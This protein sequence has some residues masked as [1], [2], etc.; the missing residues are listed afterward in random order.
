MWSFDTLGGAGLIFFER[1]STIDIL[2]KR[3]VNFEYPNIGFYYVINKKPI[4]YECWYCNIASMGYVNFQSERLRNI[5]EDN[6]LVKAAA[7]PLRTIRNKL[8]EPKFRM[9]LAKGIIG[10]EVDI[11]ETIKEI[12][13]ESQGQIKTPSRMLI[14]ILEYLDQDNPEPAFQTQK[15]MEEYDIEKKES[16]FQVL[17]LLGKPFAENIKNNSIIYN[18]RKVYSDSIFFGKIT[19]LFI[20]NYIPQMPNSTVLDGGE[21]QLLGEFYSK[22]EELIYSKYK[23]RNRIL[24]C[25]G[26]KHEKDVSMGIR[27][28]AQVKEIIYFFQTMS[29]LIKTAININIFDIEQFNSI[30]SDKKYH[31]EYRKSPILFNQ[32]S[33]KSFEKKFEIPLYSSALNDE[34]Y[35]IILS[36]G[37][38]LQDFMCQI[39]YRA[40]ASPDKELDMNHVEYL[41]AQANSWTGIFSKTVKMPDF[42]QNS[43]SVK[44]GVDNPK[45]NNKNSKSGVLI[46]RYIHVFETIWSLWNML[47]MQFQ[48]IYPRTPVICPRTNHFLREIYNLLEFPENN[49]VFL[50]RG[51]LVLNTGTAVSSID[52][53][54]PPLEI[55]RGRI[56]STQIIPCLHYIGEKIASLI[57]SINHFLEN[58]NSWNY[59]LF[60]I[61]V[62]G[63]ESPLKK[64]LETMRFRKVE[65]RTILPDTIEEDWKIDIFGVE[66]FNFSESDYYEIHKELVHV[67]DLDNV[68]YMN[69][70]KI[71]DS[72]N[73]LVKCNHVPLPPINYSTDSPCRSSIIC[74]RDIATEEILETTLKSGNKV[75]I[76]TIQ[77]E[78][79]H[80]DKHLMEE[81]LEYLDGIEDAQNRFDHLKNEITKQ[82]VDR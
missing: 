29:T 24:E 61:K 49:Q 77:P 42:P 66:D 54:C 63:V 25:L 12:F 6:L 47:K 67:N 69:Y 30:C 53:D 33:E 35:E 64:Y 17:Q 57:T 14:R 38:E 71:V 68:C 62:E 46:S 44:W 81:L 34:D 82:L 31:L 52:E 55:S 28:N 21:R 10:H 45:L 13:G 73:N 22:L 1:D 20:D 16:N 27:E 74:F 58:K 59:T 78:F 75:H 23:N 3:L 50:K 79:K 18:L 2:T 11:T 39:L 65:T 41:F 72:F 9:A 51:T 19:N 37:K 36:F 80:M 48:K 26:T 76:S 40:S 8:L 4:Q 70:H 32:N 5:Y 56:S 15:M 7:K 43:F 60:T